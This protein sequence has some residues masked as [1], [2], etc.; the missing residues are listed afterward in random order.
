MF[1]IYMKGIAV[2]REDTRR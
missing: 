2:C 1:F